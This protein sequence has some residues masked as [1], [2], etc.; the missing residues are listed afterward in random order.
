MCLVRPF[1]R[2]NVY[3]IGQVF[4]VMSRMAGLKVQ[5]RVPHSV[6][7]GG[8]YVFVANHQNSY[9]LITVCLSAQKGVVTVGKKSLVWIP[10]FGWLYW[11][12]G[13]ILIDRKN[14]GRAHDTLNQT[15]DKIKQRNLSVYF[16]PEGT[17]SRGRGLLSFKTGAFR[18]A[19]A[20]NEPVVMVCTSNLQNKIKLNR[21]NNGILIIDLC[22]PITLDDSKDAKQWA[23]NI[24]IRMQKRIAELDI[25]VAEIE[26]LS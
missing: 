8:P 14:K 26:E 9:D 25:E 12:S 20:V 3:V 7:E 23:D 15:V 22:E 10:V 21:W 13:N 11:L 19:K 24:R 18:I 4:G 6:K 16:F 17:R 2:N 1:H 5:L